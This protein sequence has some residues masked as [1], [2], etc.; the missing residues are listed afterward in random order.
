MIRTKKALSLL[1][2]KVN[3]LYPQNFI[4]TIG[5]PIENAQK[6]SKEEI[7]IDSLQASLSVLV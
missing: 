4:A 2:G 1:Y 5:L 3:K 7:P 6:L